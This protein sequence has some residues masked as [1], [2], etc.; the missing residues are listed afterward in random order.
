MNKLEYDHIGETIFKEKLENGLTV[1]LLPK[2][3]MAK[4]YSIFSTNFGSID[5]SFVPI[6]GTEQITVPEG[7][8]HFLEHKMFEKEDRDVF[9]DFGKQGASA[10]AYTS[11]TKTAYLFSATNHIAK[12]IQ[13]LLDFVQDP[14]FSEESVEKE[15]GIIAQEIEM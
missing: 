14:Y 1:F 6:N 5:Q 4:T 13:T 3:E 9:A 8:A 12:N 11:F 10:N 15:K 7:V 2:P